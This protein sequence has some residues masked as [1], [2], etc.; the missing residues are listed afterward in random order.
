[1]ARFIHSVE[2]VEMLCLFQKQPAKIW[3]V[4]EVFRIIQSSEKSVSQCLETFA[5]AGLLVARTNGTYEFTPNT[6]ELAQA[7][8]ELAAAYRERRV[9]VVEAI[10]GQPTDAVKD[11]ANAFRLRKE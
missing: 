2:Q 9:A 7:V 5:R 3:T 10:Y 11:F 8:A 4:A 6:P 1:M